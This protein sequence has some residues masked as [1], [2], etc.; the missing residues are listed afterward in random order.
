MQ[1]RRELYR[2]GLRYRVDARVIPGVHRRADIVIAKLRIAIFIDGCF[3]HG[4][5]VHGTWPKANAE[6]WREK[7][8]TNKARDADTNRRLSA[9]GWTVLRFWEHES[10]A[11]Q[12]ERVL[13]AVFDAQQE[14]E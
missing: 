10:I 11:A 9:V 5:P 14:G 2:R 1:L 8:M 4:C 12:V 7:I 13:T 6:F 3:W